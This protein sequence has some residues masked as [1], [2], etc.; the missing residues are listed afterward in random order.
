MPQ[1]SYYNHLDDTGLA[2]LAFVDKIPD[3]TYHIVY[4]VYIVYIDYFTCHTTILALQHSI[5]NIIRMT[6][7]TR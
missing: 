3:L 7:K 5:L 1:A 6:C 4:I 2:K